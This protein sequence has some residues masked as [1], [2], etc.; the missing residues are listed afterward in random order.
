MEKEYTGRVTING[1]ERRLVYSDRAAV[2][3]AMRAVM[4]TA[5]QLGWQVQNASITVRVRY[6]ITGRYMGEAVLPIE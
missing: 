2:M 6:S 3:W 5:A 1:L 4:E